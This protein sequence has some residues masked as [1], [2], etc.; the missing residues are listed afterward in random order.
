MNYPIFHCLFFDHTM[1]ML[2]YMS[3]VKVDNHK[4]FVFDVGYN[5]HDS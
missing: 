4:L 5:L 1:Y 2:F 3:V